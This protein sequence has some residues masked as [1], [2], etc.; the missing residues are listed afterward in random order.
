VNRKK[1]TEKP[2]QVAATAAQTQW[3]QEKMTKSNV[4]QAQQQTQHD[5]LSQSQKVLQKSLRKPKEEDHSSSGG[6]FSWPRSTSVDVEKIGS[7]GNNPGHNS[8]DVQE[9]VNRYRNQPTN[10]AHKYLK[11]KHRAREAEARVSQLEAEI[12]LYQGKTRSLIDQVQE[13]DSAVRKA[14]E[15]AFAVVASTGPKALDDDIIRSKLKG[16]ISQWKP[17]A[18]KWAL[19][20]LQDLEGDRL[21]A[22]RPMVEE[23]VAPDESD[24]LDGLFEQHNAGKAPAILLNTELALFIVRR[25]LSMP[26][27]SAIGLG[28]GGPSGTLKNDTAQ[29]LQSLYEYLQN[30]M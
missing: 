17:F 28:N 9:V 5:N 26:F 12:D 11:Y 30:C 25:L 2:A 8:A 4:Q 15:S 18:K 10:L 22:V 14:Q 16:A 3:F 23:H 1:S 24:S 27:T 19:R 13:Q 21:E 7:S 6:W 29:T 20:S